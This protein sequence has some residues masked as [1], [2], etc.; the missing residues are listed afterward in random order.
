VVLYH[1]KR[2]Q[3]REGATIAC[4]LHSSSFRLRSRCCGSSR[5]HFEGVR[6]LWQ[7][8]G[9]QSLIG[10]RKSCCES[11]SPGVAGVAGCCCRSR[12]SGLFEGRGHVPDGSEHLADC[13][14]SVGTLRRHYSESRI[15]GMAAAVDDI[16][17]MVV[18]VAEA[19]PL[20]QNTLLARHRVDRI[21]AAAIV[22]ED[23]AASARNCAVACDCSRIHRVY[24]SCC[25]FSG[26]LRG[27]CFALNVVCRRC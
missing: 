24:C 20:D 7:R 16:A 13:K 1:D 15:F 10:C 21:L 23:G 14:S 19:R 27:F 12:W 18:G 22:D 25:R 26:S 9:V 17:D 5:G 3:W 8:F 2:N 6:K 4:L 11:S